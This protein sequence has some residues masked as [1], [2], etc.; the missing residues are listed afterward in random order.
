MITTRNRRDDLRRTLTRL[1][2]LQPQADEVIVCA[3]GC[4]DDTVNMVRTDFRNVNL[5]ENTVGQ[6]SIPSRDRMLKLAQCDWVLSLDDD[7]YP[8]DD[9]FL[10]RLGAICSSHPEAAVITFPELRND[11]YASSTMTPES[12]GHYVSAYA[13]CAA[14]MKRDFYLARPGF[15]KMFFHMYEE[16]DYALQCY[17][18]GASVWFEPS[19]TIRHH[20]SPVQRVPIRRHHQNARN[21]LWSVWMR[22]PWPQLPLVMAF[23]IWRQFR[24]ALTVGIFWALQE[25]V[26]WWQAIKGISLCTAARRPVPW[27]I[28]YAWMRLARHPIGNSVALRQIFVKTPVQ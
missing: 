9:D 27:S 20:Q 28:Y 15:P 13:N 25:P 16:P 26:W 4:T 14:L 18:A 10:A 22:C 1:G 11:G 21:E 2:R 24:Y 6:G 17:A 5:I 7:S 3:D 8:V 23:R 12:T 19:L